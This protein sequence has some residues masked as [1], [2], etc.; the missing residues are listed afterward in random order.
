[1]APAP[2]TS[3]AGDGFN[4]PALWRR[5]WP[6]ALIVALHL[7]FFHL[8]QSGMLQQ[9]RQAQTAEVVTAF[10]FPPAP[11]AAA[12][13][14][15]PARQAPPK[16]VVRPPPKPKLVAT[17]A[18]A[19]PSPPL[20]TP[21]APVPSAP[22]AAAESAPATATTPQPQQSATPAQPKTISAGVQ[23]LQPPQPEYPLQSRR[24][25]E[26]GRVI[27]RALVNPQGHAERIEVQQSS[28]FVRL[29]AAA[30]EAVARALFKPYT[31][32]G[33]AVAVF[34]IVPISF[35]LDQ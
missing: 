11:P 24:I 18:P 28:G 32:D 13:A 12:P 34:V 33:R 4:R 15:P 30:R 2:P 1:M 19:P 16:T 25:G 27:L 10:L 6:M 14:P 5:A 29:D 17:P 3:T 20:E 23:Y 35:R 22:S 7:G 9:L 8:L 31:E 26:S 21:A